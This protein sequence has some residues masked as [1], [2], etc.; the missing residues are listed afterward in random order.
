MPPVVHVLAVVIATF[1]ASAVLY[2]L[3]RR[4][5]PALAKDSALIVAV[6]GGALTSVAAIKTNSP[7]ARALRQTIA[8]ICTNAFGALERKTGYAVSEAC[9]NEIHDLA[10]P[11]GAQL[12]ENIARRGAHIDGFWLFD[13][14]TN[15]LA[16]DGLDLEHPVWVQT[17]GTITVRSPSPGIPI[18]ELSLYTTYS[19]ITVYAPLQGSYGFLPASRWPE[20]NVS[21][22]WTAVTDRG[23]RVITW[24]GALRNRDPAQPV[25]FQA[26]FKRNGDIEYHYNPPQTNYV[27]IGLYR[28]GTSQSFNPSTLRPFNLSTLQPLN[29]ST[30]KLSYIGDLGDGTG[31]TDNDGL[32][33]WQEIKVYHTDPHL[34]DT[35]GDG[36]PDGYE[37]QN[38]ADP[39]NPDT[40]DDG[41]PDGWSQE[42]YAAHRLLN[43][44]EG[45]RAITI[46]LQVSSPASNRAVLRIGDL[47]ILLGEA[48][49]WTF[50]V[51]TGTVWNVELRTDGLPVQLSLEAGV[52]VFAEN[53]EDIFASVCMKEDRPL[54]LRSAPPEPTPP[55]G[56]SRG[57][58]AKLYAPCI[59]LEPVSQVV[60][61]DESAVVRARCVPD[62]P[63][64]AGKLLWSFDPEGA[65]TYV[66]V[67]QDKLSA[68]VSGLGP[69]SPQ[70]IWLHADVGYA[71]T[72]GAIVHYCAGHDNYPTN[73]VSFP[74]NHTNATINPVFRD[75]EHPFYDDEDNPK[76]FLE[77]EIGRDTA[78][79]WQHLAWVDTDSETPGLQQRT[80]ISRDNP[81]TINW[82]AKATSSAP[83]ANGLDSLVYDDLT[84]FA[85]A[86]P[87]V[88]AGQYVPPPFA[89]IVS[90]TYD[91]HDNL[92]NEFSSTLAIPQYVQITWTANALEEFR[93][94]IVFNYTGTPTLPPTNVTLFAGCLPEDAFAAFSSIAAKVQ[95]I[96]PDNANII[97]VGPSAEI[98]QPH[99]T[100]E[101]NSGALYDPNSG[102]FSQALGATP[103]DFCHQRND[104]PSGLSY[105]FNG[106][107]RQYIFT[108]YRAFYRMSP[109]NAQNDWRNVPLPLPVNSLA[110]VMA[111]IAMHESCHAMGLVP[112]TSTMDG[113]HNKCNCGRHHMDDGGTKSPL[114]RLGI[115]P[116]CTQQWKPENEE[117]LEF[118]FQGHGKE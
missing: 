97:V 116:A 14:W 43:G 71:L 12:A 74:P 9:T 37:V 25:S 50:S 10:L 117:Y 88:A 34:A 48:N 31:D 55:T 23:S 106:M 96:F 81:P 4:F 15:R 65:S 54:N 64:L 118:V 114:M 1:L 115:I 3:M 61:G 90:R 105:V 26:E 24:E 53:V 6:F 86:L 38:G 76:V 92:I 51:P 94:P 72:T 28:G 103:P 2:R 22:I 113:R 73:H 99:K 18:E 39:L 111:Q 63:P 100:V 83:L 79:G 32:T 33:D 62:T 57:G 35:D 102:K 47:P 44:E 80:A 46:T 93:R 85:R 107:L 41:L 20:F 19:N 21:R 82:N 30:L 67:A 78:S 110:D 42:Q 56:G 101:I 112:A 77:V 45:D 52:G 75:C 11:P 70:T 27:G 108:W 58:S 40:N 87:A 7:P 59:F 17:D 98:P 109:I 29:L 66:S 84:T 16:R 8:A 49:T 104:S 68:T 36:L 13:A 95:S 89:T 60:H 91:D 5:N 69:N